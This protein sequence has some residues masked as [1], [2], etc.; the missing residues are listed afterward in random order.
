MI[1]DSDKV[2][3]A[4]SRALV[5]SGIEPAEKRHDIVFHLTDWLEE[6]HAY[7]RLCADPDAFAAD[8]VVRL[9]TQLLI[10]V[11]NH[12]AAASRLLLDVP[13]SDIFGVGATSEVDE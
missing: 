1:Y 13:V 9:L 3:S 4:I 10:H 12:L 8:E 7:Q 11:P 5:E 6:L 2:R